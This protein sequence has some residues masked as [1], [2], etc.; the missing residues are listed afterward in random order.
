MPK[1]NPS[2]AQ[3]SE[4]QILTE[5]L[6]RIEA[7]IGCLHC[8]NLDTSEETRLKRLELTYELRDMFIEDIKGLK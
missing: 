2:T 8:L 5:C 4:H 1:S 3:N 6:Q 7:M